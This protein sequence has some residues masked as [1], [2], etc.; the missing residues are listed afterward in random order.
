MPHDDAIK[1][2]R[3]KWRDIRRIHLFIAGPAGFAVLLGQLL[4]GLGPIQTYEHLPDDSIGHYRRAPQA[5]DDTCWSPRGSCKEGSG[6]DLATGTRTGFGFPAES[7][8][9]LAGDSPEAGKA[10]WA[11]D[12]SGRVR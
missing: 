11:A 5:P 1:A 3:V 4:N 12:R 8:V 6:A 2:A 7:G 10:A 9:S